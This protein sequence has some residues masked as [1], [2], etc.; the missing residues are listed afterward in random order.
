MRQRPFGKVWLYLPA[1]VWEN[2]RNLRADEL[3]V[4]PESTFKIEESVTIIIARHCCH[5]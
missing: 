1:E 3:Q 2:R 4:Y 5:T